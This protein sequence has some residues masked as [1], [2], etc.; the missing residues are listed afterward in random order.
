MTPVDPDRTYDA[1][2]VGAR[3]AGAAT[4]V[5]LARAGLRVLVID[6]GAYGTD[7][8]ST[9]ALM[10]GAVAQL[11]KWGL[12]EAVASAPTPAIRWTS[13]CYPNE[14]TRIAIRPGRGVPAL[15]APRRYLLDRI[16]IDAAT[17]S[18]A[19]VI[20]GASLVDLIRR[21][22]GRVTGARIR[23]G[24]GIAAIRA[25]IVIGADG[26]HSAV[27]RHA[28]APALR[29]GRHQSAFV[30]GYWPLPS[31]DESLWYW[32]RGAAAGLIPTNNGDCCVFAGVAHHRFAEVFGADLRAGYLRTLADAAPALHGELARL[33]AAPQL[34]GFAGHPCVMRQSVGPGWALVGDA[35]YFK[36]PI[37]AHGLTDALRDAELLANAVV[38]GD[39]VALRS[40]QA[41]RDDLSGTL[42]ELTDTI[43]SFEWRID[44]LMDLH[45]RLSEEM[46]RE[47]EYLTASIEDAKRRTA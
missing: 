36:D 25:A 4:A 21:N 9:H 37:T 32:S 12:L 28:K 26:R 34:R 18:G 20:W 46:K 22:D 35:G 13:F 19:E 33:S 15:F 39:E 6:R 45:H 41:V 23:D 47:V 43:A 42:F 5:L 10:R 17:A 7:T 2:I 8:L 14:T 1:L 24:G 27:A 3:A 29:A 11:A 31:R 44:E 38:R 40:Y 30:F 16:L